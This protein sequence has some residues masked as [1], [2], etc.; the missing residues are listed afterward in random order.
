MSSNLIRRINREYAELL[1]KELGGEPIFTDPRQTCEVLPDLVRRCRDES[2]I[3]ISTP[4]GRV[5]G[6][7]YT[8]TKTVEVFRAFWNEHSD[9][10]IQ[11]LCSSDD[12]CVYS[13]R[14]EWTP[15]LGMYFDT[16]VVLD[17]LPGALD[18]SYDIADNVV[19]IACE[20]RNL[21]RAREILRVDTD[22]PLLALL[23]DTVIRSPHP[24]YPPLPKGYIDWAEHR[25]EQN[26]LDYLNKISKQVIDAE[27]LKHCLNVENTTAQIDLSSIFD[28]QEFRRF[29][30][31]LRL[32]KGHS[33]D[34]VEEEIRSVFRGEDRIVNI[35]V[36]PAI[37][38][39]MKGTFYSM[40]VQ[41]IACSMIR[42]DPVL[43][44]DHF[45][46]IKCEIEGTKLLNTLKL[47]E[48]M[49]AA[50]TIM[51]PSFN[52]L[53]NLSMQELIRFREIGGC[54][55]FRRLFR[56]HRKKIKFSGLDDFE[57]ILKAVQEEMNHE[58]S[59]FSDELE[60]TKKKYR[61]KLGK[62][63]LS[64][65][66]TIVLGFVSMAVPSLASI[67][68]PSA[69]FSALIGTASV[70]GVVNEFLKG[71]QNLKHIEARPVG[72]I[73]K[74]YQLNAKDNSYGDLAL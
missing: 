7:Q 8:I 13:D 57:N 38:S 20:M 68:I 74:G 71:R 36:L 33:D 62:A 42:A 28:M 67:A 53:S 58:I 4:K 18:W 26:C 66:A 32:H 47:T 3:L 10:Y 54:D 55:F 6:F 49:F 29:F 44:D 16:I 37:L 34:P 59:S 35:Q 64:F 25:A 51:S 60:A 31:P 69:L 48:E 61:E 41:D 19:N 65:G 46:S 63:A 22:S 5:T 1:D 15:I 23:P 52:W 9:E 43:D 11:A 70:R 39:L 27:M 24:D 17:R 45:Y 73:L 12:M 40:A 30:K 2:G 56:N 21:Y 14:M 72:L 50:K